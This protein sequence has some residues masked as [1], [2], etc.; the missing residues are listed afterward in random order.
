M[1]CFEKH[2]LE[3]LTWALP[4]RV[5]GIEMSLVKNYVLF[6]LKGHTLTWQK[7]DPMMFMAGGQPLISPVHGKGNG[8]L[9]TDANTID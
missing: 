5:V 4:C 2:S 7:F 3:L 9:K 8:V 6:A 1:K